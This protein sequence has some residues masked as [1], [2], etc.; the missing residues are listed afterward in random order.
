MGLS[1]YLTGKCSGE[2]ER[3]FE[4]GKEVSA[5]K[6]AYTAIQKYQNFHR[7]RQNLDRC[8]TQFKLVSDMEKAKA[9]MDRIV[10]KY[11]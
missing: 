8:R 5:D 4:H 9:E 3:H 2:A 6:C 7:Q 11:C 1:A 10:E